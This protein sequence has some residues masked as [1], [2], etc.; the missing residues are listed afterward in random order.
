MGSVNERTIRRSASGCYD[1]LSVFV[2]PI[3]I[4][5]LAVEGFLLLRPDG[6]LVHAA[7]HRPSPEAEQAAYWWAKSPVHMGC[8]IASCFRPAM[9]TVSYRQAGPRGAVWRAF[10]FCN[11]HAPP[12][13]VSTL[14]YRPGRPVSA[15]YDVP[16]T[17]LWAE[18]YFFLGV[19]GFG[20][21]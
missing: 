11:V 12:G 2:K 21:W 17:P 14:V 19:V 20:A 15:S 3:V 10:G 18:V 1:D 7:G 5:V 13:E 6:V 16:L 4:A 8:S 9:R